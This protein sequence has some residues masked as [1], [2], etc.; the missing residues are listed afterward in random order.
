MLHLAI[1]SARQNRNSELRIYYDGKIAEG[2]NK[3]SV[4]NTIRAKLIAQ[5]FSVVKNDKLYS[6]S[7][8][9]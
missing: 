2:K 6:K 7:Y 9:I 4:L 5:I 8:I 1:L 3:M